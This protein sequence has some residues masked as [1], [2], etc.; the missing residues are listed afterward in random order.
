V[1]RLRRAVGNPAG[2]TRIFPPA[3]RAVGGA[4]CAGPVWPGRPRGGGAGVG[5]RDDLHPV[6][7]SEQPARSELVTTKVRCGLIES[8]CRR[9][10]GKTITSRTVLHEAPLT[11]PRSP[12]IRR[13]L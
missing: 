4:R 13:R 8:S 12:E 5:G 6:G 7:P 9:H 3:A 10:P 1:S 2:V 11:D